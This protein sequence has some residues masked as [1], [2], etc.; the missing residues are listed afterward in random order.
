MI[1]CICAKDSPPGEK[2]IFSLLAN[3]PGASGW[4][5]LHSL[6]LAR[7]KKR[8]QGEAD[9]IIIIPHEGVVVLEVK[10]HTKVKFDRR[11]WLLGHS[12]EPDPR[13]PFKQASQAMHS[14]LCEVKSFGMEFTKI[15][16]ISAVAFT[17]L[18]F[19]AKSI[20]WHDWQVISQN[21]IGA[22]P[23]SCRFLTIIRK[24][25][26]LYAS[27]NL[28]WA[29]GNI[30]F[31]EGASENLAH[32]LRPYFE[33]MASPTTERK[34]RKENLLSCTA[35]QFAVLDRL[36]GNNAIMI[37][38]PAGTGKTCLA[39]EAVRRD[40]LSRAGGRAGLFCYNRNLGQ[41]LSQHAAEKDD[42]SVASNLHRWMLEYIGCQAPENISADYWSKTLPVMAAEEIMR[43]GTAP[44]DYLV[45]DEIQDLFTAEYLDLLDLML[46]NGLSEGRWAFFGDFARQDIFSED[47][48]SKDDFRKRWA[49]SGH[50]NYRLD[51]NC[52]NTLEIAHYITL[53]GQLSPGYSSILRGDTH[54]DPE[55]L[56]YTSCGD[57]ALKVGEILGGLMNEGYRYPDIIIL[58]PKAKES[59]A[60]HLNTVPPWKGRLQKFSGRVA[61]G[62]SYC[63]IHGFKG[64]EAPVVILT[65][66]DNLSGKER[67]DLLYV[68]MSRAL[69]RLIILTHEST[70]LEILKVISNE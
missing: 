46:E 61:T 8:I 40:T 52:R 7:H 28:T 33:F 55:L 57:Q 1:P 35:Q 21:D 48:V 34:Y 20:E 67:A 13:G 54:H 45:V 62:I 24:A 59:C 32:R 18:T 10:S 37:E 3:D 70:K 66:F 63:T 38:G 31:D 12:T 23:I 47:S 5:V 11:G 58:S 9:F 25:R 36:V 29:S 60:A 39:I 15:P 65:D 44:F 19:T 43:R 26:Q 53:L 50:A 68:G 22:G 56:F 14:I 2:K 30:E 69:H 4:I 27:R 64:L 51:V 17:S 49:K 6:D 41:Y 42:G 16:Y